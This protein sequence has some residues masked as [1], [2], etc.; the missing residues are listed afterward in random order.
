MTLL[1]GPTLV[2]LVLFPLGFFFMATLPLG[3]ELS[4]ES[5]AKK[6]IGAANS[7]LYEFSQIGALLIIIL[8]E[9]AAGLYS[10]SAALIISAVLVLAATVLSL[11]LKEKKSQ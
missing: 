7:I 3:L 8:F 6:Y 1:Y 4:A 11:L 5:V 2:G 9:S 10:W